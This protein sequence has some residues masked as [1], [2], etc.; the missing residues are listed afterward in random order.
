MNM[1]EDFITKNKELFFLAFILVTLIT[2]FPLFFTGF[3]TADDFHY[4]L[5][6][7]RGQ[8]SAET[9]LF[10]QVSGRF[11]FYIVK[12]FYHIPYIFDNMAWVKVFQL[13]P[14]L[15]CFL[16]FAKIVAVVTKSKE[17]AWFFLLLFLLTMQISQ[18]TSLFVAY[19]IY[20]SF[21]FALLL[22]AFLLL[23]R[24]YEQKKYRL[25]ILASLFFGV[26]LLFYE[27]YIFFLLFAAM[28]IVFYNLK[29]K[30]LDR[31]TIKDS[32]IQFMPFLVVGIIY[33]ATYFL[34][35]VYHPSQYAGTSFG[36]KDITVGSFFLVLWH[37][38]Y[39][40]FPLTVYQST[41]TLFWDKSELISGYSPVLLKLMVNA[42]VEWLVK[43]LLVAVCGYKL[44]MV[45]PTARFRG[46]LPGVVVAVLLIF[47]PH[48]PLALTEKYTAYAAHGGMLGYVTTFFSFFGTLFLM[49]LVLGYLM[50]LLNFSRVV[51]RLVTVVLVFGFFICSVLTDF[52]NYSIAKDIRSANLRFYAMDELLKTDEFKSMPFGSPCYGKDLWDN[53]SYSARGITEQSFN[54]F[55]YFDAKNGVTFPV[56]RE[57]A[58]FL[59]YSKKIHLAPYFFTVRQAEKSEDVTLVMGRMAPVQPQDTAVNNFADLATVVY[60]S[61][62]KIFTLSFKVRS[63]TA[64]AG[65]PIKINHIADKEVPDKTVELTIY[66]TKKGQAATIF[67]IQFPGIDLNSIVISNV[68]DRRNKYFYL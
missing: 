6:T 38:A 31:Q 17:T 15:V 33:L 40:S 23:L 21:S 14:I 2:F 59:D 34:Y 12:P 56:G 63:D 65:V 5:V 44:L 47:V 49:T 42:H 24:F 46:I 60:Y 57:D 9:T 30:S 11:Y 67:T 4:Y 62:Y 8:I 36:T 35:R 22:V 64:I 18:H 19:P 41:H 53:P 25:I 37:L 1:K 54:W 27:T 10:S 32:L 20:F 48:I 3:A 66:N 26:G 68:I 28:A 29:E 61:S 43:G 39:S 50:N 55:E 13:V 58:N 16:L 52:S 45:V 51:K 7:R